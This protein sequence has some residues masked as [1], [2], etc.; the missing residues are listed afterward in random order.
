MTKLWEEQYY[1]DLFKEGYINGSIARIFGCTSPKAVKGWSGGH[2][3]LF[4][5]NAMKGDDIVIHG[6]GIQTR[7]IA[8]AESIAIGLIRMYEMKQFSTKEIFNLGSNKQASVRT[9][10]ELIKIITN[11]KS[12]IKHIS[13]NEAFGDYPEIQIRFAD[14]KKAQRI[15]GVTFDAE[16]EDIITEMYNEW[17]IEK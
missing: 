5:D 15:L 8:S 12:E 4:L 6:D 7:S 13:T 14:T 2:I 16:L 1:M 3:P 9:A 17:K 11:S 10:A